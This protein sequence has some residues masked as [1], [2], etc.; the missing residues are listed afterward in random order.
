MPKA[1]L[2]SGIKI[3]Y[4]QVGEGPDLVMVHGLTGNQAVWHLKIAPMLWDHFRI[5]TYDLR[6]HGYS[7][8]P[9]RGYSAGDMATDLEQLM[10][11]LDIEQADVVGHSFGADIALY[12]ACS[13]PE[14]VRTVVAIEAAIPAL[15]QLRSRED[16]EGWDYWVEVLRQ[17]GFQVPPERR[18][19]VDYLLRASLEVPKKWGPLQGLPRNPG[20]FLRLLDTTT[21]AEDYEVVGELTLENIA[22]IETPV[23]LIY[24]EASAFLGTCRYLQ[25]HVPN[26]RSILLPRSETGHFGPLEQPEIVAEQLLASL[27]PVTKVTHPNVQ[28]G[29]V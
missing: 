28:I 24:G 16:W 29:A 13:R 10:D 23:V 25:D 3:H 12:L 18:C 22:C 14:R 1:L 7:D 5:L 15:I 19:D 6:G 20:P 9:P 27:R 21:V 26:A 8:M 11:A 4:Q 2:K 17:S